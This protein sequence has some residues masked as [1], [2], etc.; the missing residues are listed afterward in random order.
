MLMILCSLSLAQAQVPSVSATTEEGEKMPSEMVISGVSPDFASPRDTINTF[1]LNMDN[2]FVPL[3]RR[4]GKLLIVTFALIYTS[5]ALNVDILP[6][7]GS[8]GLAGL[9]ISFAAQDM[10]RNVFGG[11]TIFL[12]K[13]FKTGER[14]L[15]QGYDGIVEKIGFRSTRVRTLN[16]H[17]VSIPN[18]GLTGDAVENVIFPKTRIS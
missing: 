9:A 1:L 13:P 16:G 15:Y 10:I 4:A 14:I 2:M 6:L 11:V 7:L 5:K 18:G 12:D 17:V 3:L 8:L